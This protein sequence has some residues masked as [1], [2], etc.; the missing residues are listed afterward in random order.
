MGIQDLI[1]GPI[2]FFIIMLIGVNIKNKMKDKDLGGYFLKGLFLKL[3]GAFGISIIYFFYYGSGDTIFYFRRA[4]LIDS[5]LFSKLDVGLKLLFANPMIIDPQTFGYFKAIRA[6]DASTY[7]V[8][9][10]AAIT[11]L[12]CFDSYLSNAFIFAALSFI[13]IWRL[14]KML[15]GIFPEKK[16]ILAWSFLFIPSVFFWGSGILKDNVT[17]GFLGIFISSFYYLFI[18]RRQLFK[19]LVLLLV[20]TYVIGIIKS[21]ILLAAI[22]S[23]F[24][25]LY[26][27]FRGKIKS[28]VLKAL[29]TPILLFFI[30]GAGYGTL[31]IAGSSFNKFSI[32]N[33]QEKA[34]D[35]QRWHTYRVE[36]LKGGDGS[37]YHL[38]KVDFTPIGILTKIPKAINAALF[39]PYLWEAGNVVVLLS[40]IESSFFLIITIRFFLL[41]SINMSAG[42]NYMS[43]NPII[44][45]M[46]VFSFIFAFSVGFTS[47]N[48]GALSRYRIPLLPFYV[49]AI[50]LVTDYLKNYKKAR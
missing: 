42:F 48:F 49:S 5:V 4:V 23:M 14:Y 34:E 35:M 2:Y 24:I 37:S 8:V 7:F 40:A 26:L 30:F 16:Q 41:F 10:L 27:K 11:N 1:I 50:L 47:F 31:Q 44:Y 38:G 18:E 39:R 20:S 17:Y 21:Y 12:F 6:W 3:F 32:D 36:V 33:A 13:G 15:L 25:W 22:P 9:K 43:K 45:F 28:S 19:N 29:A 46:F